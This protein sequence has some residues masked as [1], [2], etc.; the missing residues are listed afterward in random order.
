MKNHWNLFLMLTLFVQVVVAQEKIAITKAEDLPKHSYDLNDKDAVATVKSKAKTLELVG[1]VKKNLLADLAKYDIQ[2]NAALREYYGDLM[3]MSFIEGDD[4]KALEYIQKARALAD[5]ESEKITFGLE[6]EVVILALNQ[7]DAADAAQVRTQI[8]QMLEEKINA[9]DFAIIQEDIESLKASTEIVSENLLIGTVQSQIQPA[10]DNNKGAIP[11]DLV[12]SMIELYFYRSYMLPYVDAFNQAYTAALDK[13][14]SQIEKTNIWKE[15]A[16]VIEAQAAY[17]PVLIGIWDTGVDMPVF[18]KEKQWMNPN[19]TFDGKDTD[20]NGYVDDVYG[21]AYD[22]EGLKDPNYLDPTVDKLTD[23]KTVQSHMK[24]FMDLQAN[25]NSEEASNL[26]KHIAQLQ[27]EDINDFVEKLNAYS[28]YAHG[29]HVAGIVEE[30]NAMAQIMLVRF[31]AD[32]KNIPSPPTDE[33]IANYT[34]GYADIINYLKE[35][36]VQIVNMSWGDAYEYTLSA[37]ELN[38]IGKDD[39]ERKALAKKYFTQLY[40]AFETAIKAAPEILFICAAGNDNNDVDFAAHYP[41]SINLPNLITVGAVDIEGK[42]V[43]FTTEGKSV[44]VYANG[45]EVES[46]VPGGDRIAFSGTSMA[47]PNVANLAGKLL[48]VHPDLSPEQVIDIIIKSSTQ[49]EED[50]KVLIIHP[51]NALALASK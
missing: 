35:H 46:Y 21:I 45:Y 47:S 6:E 27:P 1:M 4:A 22:L 31:T 38:G 18:P 50:E 32:P 8:I 15:R 41:S 23:K 49:S 20:G 10:L 24:G 43:S 51:K 19:E 16:V 7:V 12:T 25:L 34:K 39:D 44:D 40:T 37:L 5:K 42:K 2:E 17:E 26:K 29:T 28:A 14:T 9:V 11:E 3:I 48:A 33:S 13:H 30:A 36:K